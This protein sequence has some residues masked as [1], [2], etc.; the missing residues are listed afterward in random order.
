MLHDDSVRAMNTDVDIQLAADGRPLDA[1]VGVRLLFEQ[2]EARFSRFRPNSLLCRLNAGAAIEDATFAAA[3]RRAIAACEFTDGLF[4][5][6]V[7]PALCDAGYAGSFET[8]AGGSPRAQ[9][10]P[11]PAHALALDGDRVQLRTGALDLGGL[12]KGWTVDLALG[13]LAERYPDALVNAG[14]DLRCAGAEPGEDGWRIAVAAPDG[15]LPAWQGAM[16]GALATSTT[17]RRRWRTTDGGEAHHLIDPRTGLPS[18]SPY[19]Q[20]SAWA[21]E[22]WVAEC[23]AKAVLIA[24]PALLAKAESAVTRILAR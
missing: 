8:V 18:I 24:G 22:T 20:V 9:P 5:P 7:L 12:V 10:V 6:M 2:Q 11:D 14:G 23:W 3:C 1:F 21:E 19:S 16:R 15:T 13:Q 4:N 17:A